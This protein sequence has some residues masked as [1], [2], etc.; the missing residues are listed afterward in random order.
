MKALVCVKQVPDMESAFRVAR[1]GV[2]Y[3]SEGLVFRMN[4]YD[5]FACEEA[6][7]IKENFGG[8]E[9]C[10]ITVGPPRA[11]AVV[12]R[13]LEFGADRAVHIVTPESSAL[14]ALETASL[15]ASW[16]SDNFFD[17][18]LAGVMSEDYQRCATG[19]ML[20]ALLDI[21]CATTVVHLEIATD[22]KTLVA[23][24]ELEAGRREMVGMPLPCLITVQSGINTPRY[25]SLT[26][27]LRAKK[28]EIETIA[29]HDLPKPN[30]CEISQLTYLPPPTGAVVVLEG[31][32]ERQ[33]EE[34]VRIIH[35]K[36]NA[37]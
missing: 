23:E 31:T 2:G 26:N 14:D 6:A 17:L 20:A 19:P 37:I 32:L 9:V 1:S 34:L 21:P 25:P 18:V 5:E 8:V 7:R 4:S 28:A 36:T 29:S 27:K 33:A 16:A 30:K 24:R 13:A 22:C 11:Q 15:I 10:A 12:R 35:G 3:D